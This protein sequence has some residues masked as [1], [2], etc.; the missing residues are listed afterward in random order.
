M[1]TLETI[2]KLTIAGS[3]IVGFLLFTILKSYRNPI[4][5]YLPE[6]PLQTEALKI[7]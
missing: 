6:S 1:F 2:I 4:S 7:D 3:F 5:Q